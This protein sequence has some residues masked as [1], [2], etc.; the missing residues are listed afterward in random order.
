MHK[1]FTITSLYEGKQK[2][3][4]SLKDV[5]GDFQEG[6]ERWLF[7]SAHDDDIIVGGGLLMQMAV[8]EGIPVEALITTDG[9][10]GYCDIESRDSIADIRR[11]ETLNSF[12]LIGVENVIWLY[13]HDG[14][15]YV[16]GGRKRAEPESP[17]VIQ[18]YTGLQNA[19]TYH[20]R[21]FRPTRV[22]VPTGNDIH[23]DHKITYEELLISL[24]HGSGD[25]WP[26][27]GIPLPGLPSVYEMAVYCAFTGEPNLKLTA[28]EAVFKK[29]LAGIGAYAS[30]RQIALIVKQIE[31]GGP[32]EYFRDIRF[33]LYSPS[34]YEKLF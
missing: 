26:E 7:V 17:C 25:I 11:R 21:R 32:I 2:K 5:M 19:Y 23:P 27:L 8:S 4:S 31:E 22:F 14:D 20:L 29:K 10:M 34:V 30:Q 15:L 9:S 3:G 12:S 6:K 1:G 33:N 16:N 24:F 18:G 28:D 13:F